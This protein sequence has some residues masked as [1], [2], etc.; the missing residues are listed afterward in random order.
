MMKFSELNEEQKSIYL[1]IARKVFG[2][3]YIYCE[4]GEPMYMDECGYLI[5]THKFILDQMNLLLPN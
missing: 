4:T 2:I 1:S 5:P 3:T